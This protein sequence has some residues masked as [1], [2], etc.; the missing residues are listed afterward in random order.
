[1]RGH[2]GSFLAIIGMA[3]LTLSL[4]ALPAATGASGKS[5]PKLSNGSLTIGQQFPDPG[6]LDPIASFTMAWAMIGSSVYDGLVFRSPELKIEPGLATSWKWVDGKHLVMQLRHGVQ[7]QDGEPFNANA[8]VFTFNRLTG[9]EGQ[10]GPEYANYNA[11]TKTQALG[12]YEV[13]FTLSHPDPTLVTKLAGYGAM[14]VPPKYVQQHGSA[15]FG[16]HPIGT[17]PFKVVKYL[18]GSE[19]VLQRFDKYWRGPAKLAKVTFLFIPEDGTRLADLQTG[20]IDI[21]QT[22]PVSQTALVKGNS[23]LHLLATMSPTVYELGTDFSVAPTNNLKVRE[24]IAEAIDVKAIIK[25]VLHG[26]ASPISTFQSALSFGND[27]KLKPYPYNPVHAK[28]LLAQAGIKPGTTITLGYVGTDST[29][30]QVTEATAAYLQK[31]GL[32]VQLEPFDGTRYYNNLIPA[33]HGKAGELFEYDWGGWTLDFDNTAVLLYTPKQFYNPSY[34]NATVTAL[35]NDERSTLSVQR[36]L[37]DFYQLD[38][39]LQDQVV[40]IPLY[41]QEDLW[42]ADSRVHNFTAPPDNRLWLWPV[43]VSQ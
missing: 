3:A 10:K 27:P 18:R 34:A 4:T 22:V 7:F 36:R 5:T 31:V 33:G 41:D 43:S 32:K 25:S 30:E 21:M 39:I 9:P 15:Y 11:I 40:G 17:G 14:I 8:V 26:Y 2:R 35:V 19:V 42:A 20:A 23:S 13:E 37:K 1:V 28:Q 38:T 12:P 24:A 6:T 29:F 16:L